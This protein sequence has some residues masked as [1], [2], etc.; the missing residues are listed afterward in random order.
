M[1]FGLFKEVVQKSLVK[2]RSR[3][4]IACACVYIACR[5]ENVPRTFKETCAESKNSKREIGRVF[6]LLLPALQANVGKDSTEKFVSRFCSSLMVSAGFE[7]MAV[8]IA[9][10]A[11]DLDIL[12]GRSPVTVIS[13]AIYMAGKVMLYFALL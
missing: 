8:R 11:V 3:L 7:S 9:E 2:N 1:T 10:G 12:P 13:A 6:K 4:S 5:M